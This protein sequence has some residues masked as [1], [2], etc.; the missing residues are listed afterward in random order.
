MFNLIVLTNICMQNNKKVLDYK[1]R[2]HVYIFS[3]SYSFC[4]CLWCQACQDISQVVYQPFQNGCFNNAWHLH[5]ILH[6]YLCWRKL[7][8]PSVFRALHGTK[9]PL[10]MFFLLLS[11]L[12][13]WFTFLPEGILLGFWNFA[14]DFDSQIK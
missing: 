13:A 3:S 1:P 12:S 7:I 4:N 10:L 8:G 2:L 14:W 6:Q 11:L 5:Y 9:C